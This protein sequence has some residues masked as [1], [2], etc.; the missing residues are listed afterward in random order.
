MDMVW[1]RKIFGAMNIARGGG[2]C[3]FFLLNHLE[4]DEWL[5]QDE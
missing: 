5:V 1:Y 3:F 2:R 4:P